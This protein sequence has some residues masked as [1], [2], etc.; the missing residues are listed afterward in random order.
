MFSALLNR[1]ATPFLGLAQALAQ[2]TA[3]FIEIGPRSIEQ[4][5]D[6][7]YQRYIPPFRLLNTATVATIG[8]TETKQKALAPGF[9]V[10]WLNDEGLLEPPLPNRR[11]QACYIR[12]KTF[13][14]F[15]SRACI[16]CK[17]W[18]H[19][20][21]NRNVVG[22]LF[23]PDDFTVFEPGT[24]VPIVFDN[25]TLR[26]LDYLNRLKS[27]FFLFSGFN[28]FIGLVRQAYKQSMVTGVSQLVLVTNGWL[29]G[30][31][32]HANELLF[33]VDGPRNLVRM[34]MYDP[35]I[36]IQSN[37]RLKQTQNM[38]TVLKA[39]IPHLFQSFLLP[40][41][42]VELDFGDTC[43]AGL[44]NREYMSNRVSAERDELWKEGKRFL[45][46]LFVLGRDKKLDALL[47][48]DLSPE[49]K[50][51]AIPALI[52]QLRR[53]YPEVV[54]PDAA[55]AVVLPPL[56]E[57][58]R[59][60]NEYIEWVKRIIGNREA[61]VTE[62]NAARTAEAGSTCPLHPDGLCA[63][64]GALLLILQAAFPHQETNE[65]VRDVYAS[66][67][68][69]SLSRKELIERFSVNL[70][71]QTETSEFCCHQG[72]HEYSA[73]D[74]CPPKKRVFPLL[75]PKKPI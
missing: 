42:H 39:M 36:E 55:A 48:T 37:Y 51:Q 34:R 11:C 22:L 28:A 44:Q 65:I 6:E 33:W 63:A 10:R 15:F 27:A 18:E 60:V 46:L 20:H 24:H 23:L 70:Y 54:I 13:T 52:K 26:N 47:P 12:S 68:T 53:H 59:M 41:I 16:Q 50:S 71:L 19:V 4:L 1:L 3:P 5:N 49:V 43:P 30:A 17:H 45:P 56:D 73:I 25:E 58:K 57:Q 40:G 66:T 29:Q 64:W 8:K 67:L 74:V 21:Y 31:E 32:G 14:E 2:T 9:T 69:G 72:E 61:Y 35:H 62:L 38:E 7:L 75:P